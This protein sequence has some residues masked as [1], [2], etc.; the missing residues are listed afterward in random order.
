MPGTLD[1]KEEFLQWKD[2]V[3]LHPIDL[4]MDDLKSEMSLTNFDLSLL[5]N[6]QL[7]SSLLPSFYK[8]MKKVTE[9]SNQNLIRNSDTFISR[10]GKVDTDNKFVWIDDSFKKA[11]SKFQLNY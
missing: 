9:L 2:N 1:R 6:K 10:E 8:V 7:R 4:P 3:P 5:D 11:A